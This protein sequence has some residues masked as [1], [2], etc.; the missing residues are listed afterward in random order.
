MVST[1]LGFKGLGFKSR[2]SQS[3]SVWCLQALDEMIAESRVYS[4]HLDNVP[5]TDAF[6]NPYTL[7]T[8]RTNYVKYTPKYIYNNS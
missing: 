4:Y 6:C 2:F 7:P 5:H 1:V 8:S 3:L